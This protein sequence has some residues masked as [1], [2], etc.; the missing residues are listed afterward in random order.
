MRSIHSLLQW[1]Y[2]MISNYALP[3]SSVLDLTRSDDNTFE[4]AM[5]LILST[6]ADRNPFIPQYN[7]SH[8]SIHRERFNWYTPFV[9]QLNLNNCRATNR[10]M[11][12]IS[13]SLPRNSDLGFRFNFCPVLLS[14]R[15]SNFVI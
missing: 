13:I 1:V 6:C 15:V 8:T 11:S 14:T 4:L 7:P 12:N 10:Y 3:A 9:Y 5:S 2:D